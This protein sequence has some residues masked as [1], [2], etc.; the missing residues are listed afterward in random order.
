MVSKVH[1]AR[2]RLYIYDLLEIKDDWQL[3]IFLLLNDSLDTEVLF[4][5]RKQ[6]LKGQE[7]TFE[8][9]LHHIVDIFSFPVH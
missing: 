9:R 3:Q 7:N 6:I 8:V 1:G 2:N 4:S 5:L